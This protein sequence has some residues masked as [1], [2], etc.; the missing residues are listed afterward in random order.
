M[1]P[2]NLHKYLTYLI[3]TVWL[4]NGLFCKLLNFVPRHQQI[5]TQ[6]LGEDYAVILTKLIGVAEIGMAVWVLSRVFSRF[7]AIVQIAIVLTM[8]VLEF[9]IVPDVL[10][11]GKLNFFFAL[12][13]VLTV[14]YNEFAL[15]EI[16]KIYE[17]L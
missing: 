15:K 16:V 6:I 3:A 10:L 13:F 8:N 4:I 7:N 5:V 14:Y 17:T 9:L 11:W 12:I 1:S 2:S